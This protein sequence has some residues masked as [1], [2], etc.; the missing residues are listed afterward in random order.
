MPDKRECSIRIRRRTAHNE[1]IVAMNQDSHHACSRLKARIGDG[2][3]DGEMIHNLALSGRQV[4][5]PV[6]LLIEKCADA[7]CSQ[8]ECFGSEVQTV[9]DS[10]RFE[11]H[12]AIAA[13]AMCAGGAL[14]VADH[15]KRYTGIAGQILTEAEAGCGDALI[16]RLHRF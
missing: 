1:M 11:M 12:I 6:H 7:G 15:R 14:Q 10:A 9:P 8:A 16:A 4:E 3:T 2:I 5:I 13:V